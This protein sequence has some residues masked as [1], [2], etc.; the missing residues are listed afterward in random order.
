MALDGRQGVSDEFMTTPSA[1]GVESLADRPLF[2]A[3]EP[4]AKEM[5]HTPSASPAEPLSMHRHGWWRQ[6]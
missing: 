6:A 1:D 5:P 4:S 3:V 2:R